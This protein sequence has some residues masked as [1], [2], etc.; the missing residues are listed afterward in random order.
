MPPCREENGKQNG[1]IIVFDAQLHL[2]KKAKRGNLSDKGLT[3]LRPFGQEVEV[4]TVN[5]KQ[6]GM[7]D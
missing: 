5:K 2:N 1:K 7:L 6:K 3:L 4:R